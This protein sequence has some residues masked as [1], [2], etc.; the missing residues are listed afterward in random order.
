MKHEKELY[1]IYPLNTSSENPGN[2][3]P[4]KPLFFSCKDTAEKMIREF[5]LHY[6]FLYDDEATQGERVYCLILEEYELDSPYRYQ[7]STRVYSPEGELL[8]DCIIPD[9]GPFL[10]RPESTINHR[11]GDF[12]ETP[13]GDKLLFGIVAGQPACLCEEN[14]QYGLSASD[15][16]YVIIQHPDLEVN[17]AHTPMVFQP[18]REIPEEIQRDLTEAL[19]KYKGS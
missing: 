14:R 5:K 8:N 2:V 13:C 4:G 6:G 11:V 17:Y 18:S 10:G 7:L 1:L 19:S 3:H 15:D 12:V 16:C 9:D